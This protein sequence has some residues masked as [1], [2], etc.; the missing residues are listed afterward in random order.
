[1]CHTA[2][3]S[4]LER[5]S[6]LTAVPTIGAAISVSTSEAVKRLGRAAVPASCNVRF[7]VGQRE[8]YAGKTN[9]TGPGSCKLHALM[10]VV[11]G[12]IVP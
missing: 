7:G 11:Q 3:Q 8:F 4:H 6:R 1:M 5:P 10:L 9:A 12:S 2:E